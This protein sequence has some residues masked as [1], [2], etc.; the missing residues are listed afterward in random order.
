MTHKQ[1]DSFASF[2]KMNKN[3]SLNIIT[4]NLNLSTCF[5]Y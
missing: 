2:L 3:M 1:S 4:L 5:L